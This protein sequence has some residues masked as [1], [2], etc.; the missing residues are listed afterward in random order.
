MLH[1]LK[2]LM[3]GL[4]LAASSNTQ[5]QLIDD[6]EANTE[7]GVTVIR[8]TFSVPVRYASHFPQNRGELIKLYL[9]AMTLEP[10]DTADRQAYR[11]VPVTIGAPGL[12]VLYT[13]VQNCY[14]VRDPICLDIRF[15][16]PVRFE[17]KPGENGRSILLYLL[18]DS[19]R[20]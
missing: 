9:Q 10:L 11:R 4:A 14:A 2:A 1:W 16:R 7:Q 12:T 6:M 18:P 8:I 5:A 17:I 20:I 19:S 13:T 3:F 15:S